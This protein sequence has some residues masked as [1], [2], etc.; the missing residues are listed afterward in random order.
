MCFP[1]LPHLF[2]SPFFFFHWHWFGSGQ[3]PINQREVLLTACRSFPLHQGEAGLPVF[4]KEFSFS[5][6]PAPMGLL[7]QRWQQVAKNNLLLRRPSKNW[8]IW[9]WNWG[10]RK[11]ERDGWVICQHTRAPEPVGYKGW[12]QLWSVPWHRPQLV[13]SFVDAIAERGN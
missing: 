2:K 11:P 4:V 10:I 5:D 7:K 6:L 9:S 3:Y 1:A 8:L 12:Q 13:D